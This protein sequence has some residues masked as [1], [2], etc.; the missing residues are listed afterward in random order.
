[1]YHE[2]WVTEVMSRVVV[3]SIISFMRGEHQDIHPRDGFPVAG[4]HDGYPDVAL[5]AVSQPLLF[6]D[7]VQVRDRLVHGDPRV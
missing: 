5:E 3:M 6:P 4:L 1:M 7:L 2:P